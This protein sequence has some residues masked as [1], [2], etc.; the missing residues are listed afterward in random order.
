[1]RVTLDGSALNVRELVG[2]ARA[3]AILE[4]GPAAR[5]RIAGGRRALES[6]LAT[7]ETF[8]GVNTG[9][10]SLS[11]KRIGGDDL[12]AL[13]ANLIR[14]H[15]AGVGEA[16][17]RE[18]VRGMLTLLAASLARGRSG[19]RVE[20]VESLA[21]MLNAGVTPIVPEIGSVG[22]SGDLAP[23]AHASLVLMGEGRAELGGEVLDGGE[24]LRRAGLSAIT[25]EAKE[26]LALING[27]HLM[28]ARLALIWH[29]L[30]R[31]FSA[32][33]TGRRCR[34]TPAAGRTRT[35][36]NACTYAEPGGC[37]HVAG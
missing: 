19:V 23:L 18:V 13:Q 16:L 30:G 26:G 28:A 3:G 4:I 5:E 37:A 21:A 35:S 7:G 17:P 34:S 8:Y 14:S 33:V 9:F 6:A 36:T 29:D 25:L 32:A 24:A 11:Q 2:V 27:T 20:L 12:R 1:M 22:A 10:G 31:V 15:A